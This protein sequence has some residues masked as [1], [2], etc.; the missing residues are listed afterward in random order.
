VTSIV[1]SD[2]GAMGSDAVFE[3]MRGA[4]DSTSLI[5]LREA[6][7]TRRCDVDVGAMRRSRSRDRGK[8]GTGSDTRTSSRSVTMTT[9][10]TPFATVVARAVEGGPKEL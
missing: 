1:T 7:G 9:L 4:T 6:M 2:T 5:D 10:V 8:A 3:P